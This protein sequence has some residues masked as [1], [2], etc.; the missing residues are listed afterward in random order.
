M[1]IRELLNRHYRKLYDVFTACG[2]TESANAVYHIIVTIAAMSDS[3]LGMV[4]P[5]ASA[6]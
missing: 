2:D 3:E 4:R 1:L 6:V 5:Y